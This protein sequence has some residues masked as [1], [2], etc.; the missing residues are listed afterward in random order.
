MPTSGDHIQGSV[1]PTG[2]GSA[3]LDPA[4]GLILQHVRLLALRRIA[5]LRKIWTGPVAGGHNYHTE[6]NDYLEN[7]DT[8]QAEYDWYD[9]EESLHSLN[10]S[11]RSVQLELAAETQSR[12][13]AF[14]QIFG[15]Q[16]A[17]LNLLQA[18]VALAIEPGFARIYTY[19]Q[20]HSGRGYVTEEL[21]ARLFG[22]GYCLP[23]SAESPLKTW[24]LVIESENGPGE[25][26]RFEC[27]PFIRNWLLGWDDLDSSLVGCVQLQPI[28]EPLA[29]WPVPAAATAIEQTFRQDAQARIRLF[30]TGEKGSGRRSFA[31]VVARQFGL[32]LLVVDVDRIPAQQW[33]ALY[34]AAQRQAFLH[35]SALAWMGTTFPERAWPKVV[36]PFHLQFV[37]DEV[38]EHLKD[39]E[40]VVDYHFEIP[41]LSIFERVNLWKT[42]VPNSAAWP[43]D[44]LHALAQRHQSTVGQI[45]QV[46]SKG[47]DSVGEASQILRATS[48]KR[49]GDLAQQLDCPFDWND[50]VLPSSLRHALEDFVFEA[51][52]G[53]AI[54]ER[55][56]ANR[57]F[58]QG[59]G[60]IALLNGP[61]GT[62]KTMAAQVI[63][64]KL[65]LDLFR[66][67]L[68]AVVSKY[69]GET[70]KNLERILSRAR[71]MD[72]LLLFDEA[73][74]LFGKRTEIRDAHDRFANTDTNYLLQAIEQYPGIAILASNKKAN[75][76]GGFVRRLRYILEFPKPEALQRLELWRRITGELAGPEYPEIMK[77]DLRHLAEAVEVTGAQIKFAVLSGIFIAKREKT[78]FSLPCLLR[79]LERELNKEGRGLG[80]Q[81]HDIFNLKTAIK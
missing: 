49:L 63:A 12:W 1:P 65:Q 55:P 2:T 8:P 75:L 26:P 57:L 37:I 64:A 34:I 66:I 36:R 15:L 29:G 3:K 80:R 39:V 41:A 50:L 62:G 68:S 46:A 9:Q 47:A 44:A 22:H 32:P 72:A 40:G 42:L 81:I 74:A 4:L 35:R 10:E 48:R 5:W 78:D 61:P 53:R 59:K 67:D 38:D 58:P 28:P 19:L 30:I 14:G 79:G 7:L 45:M 69:V 43:E 17:E 31:A 13:A 60:L 27:H 76:D 6:V 20:D 23:V 24:R 77:N 51:T 52:E 21:V 70:S 54:W 73:D 56:E 25:P 11:I 71:R 33:E 16:E 18:C